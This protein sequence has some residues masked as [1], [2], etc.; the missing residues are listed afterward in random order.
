MKVVFRTA[1]K[2][3]RKL[4]ADCTVD[5]SADRLVG[6]AYLVGNWATVRWA[7]A[8]AGRRETADLYQTYLI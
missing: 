4:T 8:V 3:Y 1:T 2:C 6:I 7:M 5:C